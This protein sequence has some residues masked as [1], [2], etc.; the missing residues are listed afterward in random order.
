M[1]G[2]ESLFAGEEAFAV[3]NFKSNIKGGKSIY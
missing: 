1:A 3:K 2:A